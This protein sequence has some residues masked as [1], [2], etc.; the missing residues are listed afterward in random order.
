MC[1]TPLDWWKYEIEVDGNDQGGETRGERRRRKKG[2]ILA[3]K[4]VFAA[5]RNSR[6]VLITRR[7]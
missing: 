7:E 3:T 5:A 2:S 6:R 1:T 4:S